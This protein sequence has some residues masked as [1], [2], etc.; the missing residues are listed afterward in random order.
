MLFSKNHLRFL[1]FST[2]SS[3]VHASCTSSD[4]RCQPGGGECTDAVRSALSGDINA[5]I[6][7]ILYGNYCGGTNACIATENDDLDGDED[8]KCQV[9]Q[10]SSKKSKKKSKKDKKK[11]ASHF[12]EPCPALPCDEVDLACQVHDSCLTNIIMEDQLL[13]GMRIP[14]PRRCNCDVEFIYSQV[15][16]A[17]TSE[18]TGLCDAAFYE[19]PLSPGFP[20]GIE[21]LQHESLL[22]AAGFCC[23]V[24]KD[25]D[26][27]GKPDCGEDENTNQDQFQVAAAYCQ[28]FLGNLG[29]NIC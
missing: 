6:Y 23:D 10:S 19:E 8:H 13:P 3:I 27:D 15:I 14:V 17:Q 20:S 24:I 18:A 11:D 7:S 1:L 25:S 2:T 22:Q 28:Q 9:Q 26:G 16:T 21:L 29:A 4:Q 5:A 12:A